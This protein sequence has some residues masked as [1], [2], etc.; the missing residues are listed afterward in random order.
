MFGKKKK[1]ERF[2]Y[3]VDKRGLVISKREAK[4]KAK[5]EKKWKIR[6]TTGQ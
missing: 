5:R 4:R 3:T 6:A 1:K 2:S